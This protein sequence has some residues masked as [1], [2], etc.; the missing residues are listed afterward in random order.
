MKCFV[1][2]FHGDIDEFPPIVG[3]S[4]EEV[5]IEMRNLHGFGLKC[6]CE[7]FEE[8]C[9]DHYQTPDPED[10]KIEV[11]EYDTEKK[12]SKIVWG[13][14]GWHWTMPDDM[15]QGRMPGHSKSLY[16]LVEY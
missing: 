3:T 7:D 4:L 8:P 14:W 9:I 11:W 12:T 6:D 5:L 16:E 15:E 10:D 13:F 1:A 2:T